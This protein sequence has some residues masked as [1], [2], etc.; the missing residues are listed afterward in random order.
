[1]KKTNIII[2][3]ILSI[4]MLSGFITY[5][6]D[7]ISSINDTTSTYIL[8]SLTLDEKL[9]QLIIAGLPD[10]NQNTIDYLITNKK[11][12]GIIIFNRNVTDFESLYKLNNN[13]KKTNTKNPLPIFISVDEEGGLVS[14]LPS[15]S[16]NF[17]STRLIGDNLD[18]DSIEKN[19]WIIGREL[20]SLGFN[21]NMAPVL[22]IVDDKGYKL[23]FNRT[24]SGNPDIVAQYSSS[25]IKGIEKSNI[26]PVAKHFPGHGSASGDSH[27]LT[28]VSNISE[29]ELYNKELLPYKY[30][31]SKGLDVIM[32]AHV[33][34]P[35][36]DKTNA[37]ASMSSIIIDNILRNNMNYDG[38]VVTD[39][40]D[41]SGY[42]YDNLSLEDCVI[43]SFNAG[44]DIFLV[45]HKNFTLETVFNALKNGLSDG[46]ISKKRLNQSVLRVI[47]AK[48]KY[49]LRDN[50]E[51]SFSK[52][53]AI[54]GS[55][56]HD[57][58]RDKI[59]NII[60]D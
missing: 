55:N 10:N 32:V 52:A 20:L 31:I 24:Y 15:G 44:V 40:L 39:D 36:I 1:M 25:F 49:K 34:Y 51:Y 45:C 23:L 30:N 60:N 46:R 22:D 35:N 38:L 57:N 16:T 3:I 56:A 50:M 13:I 29:S 59:V 7:C 2:S 4:F 19:G 11:V 37:P 21:T 48:Q 8:N 28:P 58:I 47:N 14:R 17:P 42:N 43:K 5:P 12:G 53:K 41:M 27:K 9:G 6:L 54:Y 26:I 18:S 33:S